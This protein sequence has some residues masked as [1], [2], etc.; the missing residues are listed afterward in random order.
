MKILKIFKLFYTCALYDNF[1]EI[2]DQ[3]N[4]SKNGKT[5]ENKKSTQKVL[6]EHYNFARFQILAIQGL[7]L[8]GALFCITSFYISNLV[9]EPVHFYMCDFFYFEGIP[10]FHILWLAIN[11]FLLVYM[12]FLMFFRNS[13]TI[14]STLQS[15]YRKNGAPSI[16]DFFVTS[17]HRLFC[18]QKNVLI[19]R[20]IKHRLLP[21]AKI[22][23]IIINPG[24][25][26]KIVYKCTE[27]K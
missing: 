13:K 14:F 26:I 22:Y 7:F 4:K 15:I 9:L 3:I 21:L 18:L 27:T 11:S 5:I 12:N 10:S 23:Q 17:S 20:L 25:S 1:F 2:V 8:A 19:A 16:E 6:H 24:S